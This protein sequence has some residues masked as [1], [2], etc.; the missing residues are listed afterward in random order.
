MVYTQYAKCAL[1]IFG[2][3]LAIASAQA[4]PE[5]VKR[6]GPGAVLTAARASETEVCIA[7]SLFLGISDQS[8]RRLEGMPALFHK[9]LVT[10]T[11]SLRRFLLENNLWGASA[12]T[13]G[14]CPRAPDLAPYSMC[15]AYR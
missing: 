5:L 14:T 7:I 1:L 3:A 15:L 11:I 8:L 9:S 10:L 12:A 4:M 2:S 13:S 6:A